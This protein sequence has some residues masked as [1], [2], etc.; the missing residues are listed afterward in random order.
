MNLEWT[1]IGG[2]DEDGRKDALPNNQIGGVRLVLRVD[3]RGRG[4][5]DADAGCE[6]T[7]RQEGSEENELDAGHMTGRYSLEELFVSDTALVLFTGGLLG[8]ER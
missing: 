2:A 4:V 8:E 1:R 5:M 7:E 3:D 6:E